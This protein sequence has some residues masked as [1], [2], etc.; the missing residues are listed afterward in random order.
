MQSG[1][2]SL[3]GEGLVPVAL[4]TGRGRVW[5]CGRELERDSCRAGA[6]SAWHP[7]LCTRVM[8]DP[9][10]GPPPSLGAVPSFPMIAFVFGLLA[11]L[12]S[13]LRESS[14]PPLSIAEDFTVRLWP[15]QLL[16]LPQKAEHFPCAT[17]L[18]GHTGPV[19]CCSFSTDG[20]RL[21]T[22]GRDL[23]S[24][25]PSAPVPEQPNFCC[26]LQFFA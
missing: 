5:R 25:S 15:R 9:C 8:A 10:P 23:V 21:A 11:S 3:S 1:L 20:C 17:E 16:T 12:A 26:F 19:N 2:S 22:G 7:L 18:W 6:G 14:S 4:D 13:S 24:H